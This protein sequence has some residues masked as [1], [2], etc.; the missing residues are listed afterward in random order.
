MRLQNI[1]VNVIEMWNGRDLIEFRSNG[2]G[3]YTDTGG[4]SLSLSGDGI[5]YTV[6]HWLAMICS[7]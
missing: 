5:L 6:T 2:D 1:S 3:T 4:R 7:I